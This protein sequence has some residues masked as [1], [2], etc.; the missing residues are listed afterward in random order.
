MKCPNCEKDALCVKSDGSEIVCPK[1]GI[2]F[3]DKK[4]MHFDVHIPPLPPAPPVNVFIAIKTK[5]FWKLGWVLALAFALAYFKTGYELSKAVHDY[6]QTVTKCKDL[7]MQVGQL[8]FELEDM[9]KTAIKLMG[10]KII[11]EAR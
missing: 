1:C 9:S 3:V 5:I 7:V 11:K 6:Q 10:E 8:R 4:S 2:T